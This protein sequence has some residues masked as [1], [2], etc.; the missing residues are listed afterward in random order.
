MKKKIVL[1]GLIILMLTTISSLAEAAILKI[2][3]PHDKKVV[4]EKMIK[5]KGSIAK[6][7]KVF[8]NEE[9]APLKN[10]KFEKLIPLRI[11]K[12]LIEIEYKGFKNIKERKI[13]R[14]LRLD[15]MLDIK[16]KFWAKKAVE[17][18]STLGIISKSSDGNY[19][20]KQAITKAVITTALIKAKDI[21]VEL[22]VLKDVYPD[23]KK[24]YWGAPFI[25]AA[26]DIGLIKADASGKFN[27]SKK[28][29]R[30]QGIATI[31][32]FV[33]YKAKS[34]VI[35]AP[36]K[37]VPKGHKYAGSIAKAKEVQLLGSGKNFYPDKNLDKAYLASLLYKLSNV[38]EKADDMYNWETYSK[39]SATVNK[40]INRPPTIKGVLVRPDKLK[41]D[42]ESVAKVI[43]EVRDPDGKG[44]ISI[45]QMN[46]K[47]LGWPADGKVNLYDD[48]I[49]NGDETKGD[50][51][52]TG[53]ILVFKGVSAGNKKIEIKAV[54]L[55][56]LQALKQVKI[57][58]TK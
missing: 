27:P 43:V 4:Y 26:K 49:N 44:D 14:I 57:K 7:G 11:G 41:A 42:G 46:L 25:K 20:P 35:K 1:Q 28:I 22:K 54:D 2:I 47:N 39:Q 5:V 56:G 58:V 10:K 34:Q 31:I 13:I 52:Y 38:K 55:R 37:D 36:Y 12:N 23:V 30:A 48:G 8:I 16:E 45:V 3:V 32:E 33:G 15:S 19:K 51:L 9:A 18:L 17:M 50:G 53:E 24:D 40:G 21:Q 29:T 6:G